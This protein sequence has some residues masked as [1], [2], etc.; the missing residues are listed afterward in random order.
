MN[1]LK[2]YCEYITDGEHGS[3]TWDLNGSA[4]LLSAKNL[5]N[6]KIV[7]TPDDRKMSDKDFSRIRMRTKLETGDVVLSTTGTIGNVAI[8]GN[9][10]NYDFNRDVGIFKCKQTCLYPEYLYYFFLRPETKKLFQRISKGAT[11]KH[12]YLSDFD[13]M[14]VDFPDITKQIKYVKILKDIDTKIENNNAICSDLESMAKLLYDYWFVQF[15][16]PD[17]NGKPYK[18]SGGKMVWNETL[19]REIPEGWDVRSISDIATLMTN[20]V[21]PDGNN[22]YYHYSIPAYDEGIM[23]K[24]ENG[25]TIASNKYKV[26]EKCILVSKLN[27]QFKRIWFVI[28]ADEN[29]ICSTEFLPLVPKNDD[30][31]YLFG[32]L[33][34][35]AFSVHLQQ[36]ASSSTGSRKRID[37]ENCMTFTFAHN[38]QSARMFD[39]KVNA[40]YKKINEIRAENQQLAELRDF[41]LPMLMNGQVKIRES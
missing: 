10:D 5:V 35:D 29:A 41:L 3:V 9:C 15:D 1:K 17:E 20:S 33:N 27:P 21:I 24:N 23:P 30:I 8:I 32:L 18:S 40:I 34:S 19:K 37:P 7:I 14:I 38:N 22:S 6:G 2:N 4:Y 39:E 25:D 26:P 36:K 16:F 13:E 12:L 11:Q 31:N 28:N